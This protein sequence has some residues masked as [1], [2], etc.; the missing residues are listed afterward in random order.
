M[1]VCVCCVG[2]NQGTAVC[3]CVCVC[4]WPWAKVKLCVCV[5]PQILITYNYIYC[6]DQMRGGE[7]SMCYEALATRYASIAVCFPLVVTPCPAPDL[8]D[9]LVPP[10]SPKELSCIHNVPAVKVM[11]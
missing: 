5:H 9:L 8:E 1:C 11:A 4:V 2:F 6:S 3:V 10:T 7:L